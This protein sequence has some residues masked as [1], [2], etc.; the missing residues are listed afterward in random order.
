MSDRMF[1]GN[2]SRTGDQIFIEFYIGEFPKICQHIPIFVE[3]GQQ[4]LDLYIYTY[5]CIYKHLGRN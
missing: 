2:K 1:A 5:M 3:I 4:K